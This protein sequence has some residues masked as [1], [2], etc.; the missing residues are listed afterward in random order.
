[1]EALFHCGL[2]MDNHHEAMNKF[3]MGIR[4]NLALR[5]VGLWTSHQPQGMKSPEL[6]V[7]HQ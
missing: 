4:R 2:N 5:V 6:L 3:G 7:S 1:M